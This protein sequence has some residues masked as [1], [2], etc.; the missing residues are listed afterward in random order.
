MKVALDTNILAYAEGVNGGARQATTNTW[1][2]AA[3]IGD[4]VIPAQAL[5]ELFNLLVRK[6]GRSPADAQ[7]AVLAWRNAYPVVDTSAEIVVQA[8]RLVAHHG[9]STWDAVI[10][11]AAGAAGCRLLLSEDLQDGFNW[12][13]LTVVNPYTASDRS[14]DRS[15]SAKASV[16]RPASDPYPPLGWL[17]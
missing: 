15:T 6:A 7:E 11:A 2:E 5:G 4:V 12:G 9:L 14:T 13:G 16:D 17:R 8:A 3:P 10:L 1:L